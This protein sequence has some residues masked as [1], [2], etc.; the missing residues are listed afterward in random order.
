VVLFLVF[1][2]LFFWV[3]DFD[4]GRGVSLYA[5]TISEP[6]PPSPSPCKE[7]GC[8]GM[9]FFLRVPPL[10]A[11]RGVRGEVVIDRINDHIV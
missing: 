11:R 2:F 4:V 8:I 1:I 9:I 3:I 6:H 7:K 10:L 5:L